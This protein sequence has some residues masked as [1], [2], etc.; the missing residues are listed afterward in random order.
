MQPDNVIQPAKGNSLISYCTP[1]YCRQFMLRKLAYYGGEL[2]RPLAEAM[3]ARSLLLG[4]QGTMDRRTRG[5]RL[6]SRI[7][8]H[9]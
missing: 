5:A 7:L 4:L 3:A 1:A 6:L 9:I 2:G 8:C